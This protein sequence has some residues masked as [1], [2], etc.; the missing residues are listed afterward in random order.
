MECRHLDGNKINNKLSN[1]KWG[2]RHEN[3]MDCVRS[4]EW[5]KVRRKLS[6]NIRIKIRKEYIP[7]KISQYKLAKKYGVHQ[8]TICH[9]L[10]G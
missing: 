1:L 5:L 4:G 10:K 9:I 7:R 2:T 3:I 8:T 6:E